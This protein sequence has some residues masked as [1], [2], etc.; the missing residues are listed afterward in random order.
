MNIKENDLFQ[1]VF[2][3]SV[4]GILIVN[5]Q[6]IILTANTAC[7]KIFGYDTGELIDKNIDIL[8]PD[9]FKKKHK[10]HIKNY[11]K[12]PINRAVNKE[13]DLLGIKKDG[14]QLYLDIS[15]SPTIVNGN[16]IA[17][18][19]VKDITKQKKNIVKIKQTN[20]ALKDANRKFNMLINNQNGIIYRCKNSL[21]WE[22]EYI[23]KG[24]LEITGYHQHEF[25]KHDINFGQLI[26]PEDQE[27]TWDTVQNAIKLKRSYSLEY[28]IQDKNGDIKNLLEKG[29]AV[30]NKNGKGI[31]LEGF[32]SDITSHKKTEQTLKA[33]EAKIK[34]L[35]E[36]IPDMIF[37]QN[38]QGD[39][40]DVYAQNTEK[41]L[42]EP[43]QVIGKNMKDILPPNVFKKVDK[44]R[45]MTIKDNQI[46]VVEYDLN[47]EQGKDYFEARMVPLNKHSILTIVRDITEKKNLE[48]SIKT[49]ETRSEA[50]LQASPDLFIV[51]DKN[52]TV[53]EVYASNPSLLIAPKEGLLGKTAKEIYPAN[54]AN[55]ITGKILNA[56]KRNHMEFMQMKIESMSGL[57]DFDFR[58]VPL[59][60]NKILSI[61]R[62]VTEEKANE[63][64]LNI[65]NRALA[66]AG[67]GII[68]VDAQKPDFPIIYCNDS[69]E[70]ITGYKKDEV[71][72]M[73][74]RFLQNDDR[75]QKEIDIIKS[76]IINGEACKVTLRNYRKDGTIFW[77]ELTITPV[78][79]DEKELTHFIG[80]Q[81]DVTAKKR[82]EYLKD[83]IR[84]ILEKIAS[85][86]PLDLIGNTITETIDTYFKNCMSSILLLNKKNNTFHILAAP[87]I[88][89]AYCDYIEG[90]IIGPKVGSCGA[91]AFFKKEIVVEDIET[92]NLWKDYKDI[93]IK[94][95]L[96][97]CWSYPIISSNN[98]VIGTFDVY[99]KYTRKPLKNEKDIVLDMAHLIRVAIEQHN[100]NISIE[101]N[102][103]QL[104]KYSQ[105][106]EKTIQERTEELTSTVQKLVESNLD[107]EDQIQITNKAKN[108]ALAEKALSSAIAKNFPK[109]II[110]VVSKNFEILFA[111]GEALTILGLKKNML[112]GINIDHISTFS[113]NRKSKLKENVSRTLSGEHLYFEENYNNNYYSV[114][115]VPFYDENKKAAS[116]LIVYSDISLQKQ[117]E[118]NMEIALK[119]EQEL[120][121]LKSRFIGTASHEFRTPLS[122]IQ[123]S[124][125]L[126]G[127]QNGSNKQVE[128]IKYVNKI[129][130]NVNNLELI[131]NDFLSLNRLDEGNISATLERFDLIRLSK[132]LVEEIEINIKKG[133]TIT[134]TN[135]EN[136]IPV[137]LD[138]KLMRHILLNLLSNAT[139]YSAENTEITL[140]ILNNQDKVSL[141]IIDQGIGIPD[142]DQNNL[143]QRF[144]RAK[145]ASN[146]EGTGIGLN[147]VKHYVELMHGTI[148]FKSTLNKGSSFIIELPNNIN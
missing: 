75:D 10:V 114:N 116:A 43:D 45:K 12:N 133:Q 89:K 32:I 69:F 51:Y 85:D 120:N 63:H 137:N 103:N 18:A 138:S 50:I 28:R 148:D 117:I 37:I 41:L 147:I 20:K 26:V 74:C 1:S 22:M 92:N 8:I 142:E 53:L 57:L 68:I 124:A 9:E 23:S 70:K 33:S 38:F 144:F 76:S 109:G 19:F 106:L 126:I 98:E 2:Q 107:L 139:K 66:D 52:T 129:I 40:E 31:A 77:N 61:A 11:A 104:E 30:F 62:N 54:V 35:L 47:G 135:N 143:F 115:T 81:N 78:H 86:K 118:F 99:S 56:S 119:K 39:F 145:N 97:S 87:N 101:K 71:Y 95:G 48:Q 127:K 134:I 14:T 80:V 105:I 111:E 27:Y 125:I 60:N 88:P 6:G 72:G 140:N 42:M 82:E 136:N 102:K 4:E 36:A 24:C 5:S 132:S 131:L 84:K 123:T 13:L 100:N 113:E 110:A 16:Q 25:I 29:Q 73:N 3:A 21:N 91:A 128:N 93:A 34:A 141:E 79:N 122:V 94:N 59:A 108:E 55:K 121:E 112:E 90:T 96:K 49:V 65:R 58:F 46:H 15:L 7:E 64:L 44:A 67:N 17:I 146:I 130:K 83:Q